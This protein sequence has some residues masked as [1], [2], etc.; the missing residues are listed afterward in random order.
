MA[1]VGATEFPRNGHHDVT[2]FEFERLSLDQRLGD[3]S[4]GRF[5][6]SGKGRSRDFHFLGR[7]LLVHALQVR[8]PKRLQ[9]IEPQKDFLKLRKRDAPG[10]EIGARRLVA[11]ATTTWRTRHGT[12]LTTIA[13]YERMLITVK[14]NFPLFGK[15]GMD[16]SLWGKAGFGKARGRSVNS[17]LCLVTALGARAFARRR[18]TIR[19]RVASPRGSILPWG[20]KKMRCGASGLSATA[21][22]SPRL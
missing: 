15:W 6:D 16:L 17:A 10:L 12:L 19:K 20:E 11:N 4:A 7:L 21:P 18:A 5:D 3:F 14:R 1:A 2:S 9:L 8:Q 22:K 13:H